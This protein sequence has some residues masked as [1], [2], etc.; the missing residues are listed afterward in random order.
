MN[1]WLFTMSFVHVNYAKSLETKA[2]VRDKGFIE[3]KQT[4]KL[5]SNQKSM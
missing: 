1:I 4:G 5:A 2:Q 3:K